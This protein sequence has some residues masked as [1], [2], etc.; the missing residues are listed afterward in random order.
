MQKTHQ[1][2]HI[3]FKENKMYLIVDDQE[4]TF[5]LEKIL[6]KLFNASDPER[7]HYKISPSGY[8]IHWLSLDEDLSVDGLPGI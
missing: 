7:A 4:Y 8:G 5:L 6:K 3:E 2:Q 1:V